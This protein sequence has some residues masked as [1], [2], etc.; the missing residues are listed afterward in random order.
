MAISLPR[1]ERSSS[2]DSSPMSLPWKRMRPPTIFPTL[3]RSR[4]MPSDT[5]DLPQPL[6][7]TMPIASPGMTLQEKSITAGIS[8]RRVKKEID[9][10]SISRIGSAAAA[11]VDLVHGGRGAVGFVQEIDRLRTSERKAG[12]PA[13]RRGSYEPRHATATT[14]D[15][16]PPPLNPSATARAAR[17]P[18]RLRPEHERHQRQRRR[19]RRMDEGAQQRLASLIAVPQSGLSGARPRPK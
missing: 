13:F 11:M 9:R 2:S 12:R 19:Q 14:D 7:P 17:R 5:V 3:E 4:M 8:P 6:S 18:S 1:I 15:G 10:F 16:R